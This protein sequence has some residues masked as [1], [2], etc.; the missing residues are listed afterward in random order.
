MI[1]FGLKCVVGEGTF[2]VSIIG[3]LV[4]SSVI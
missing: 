3:K 4:K 1:W 2:V